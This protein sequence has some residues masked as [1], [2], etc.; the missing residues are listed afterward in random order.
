MKKV[1]SV[2]IATLMLISAFA[3]AETA[4]PETRVTTIVLEGME[5][6]ITET[7]YTNEAGYSIWYQADL[8]QL[9]VNEDQAHLFAIDSTV[10]GEEPGLTTSSAY[11]LIVPVEI[12]YEDTDA[13]LVEAT[14]GFDPSAAVISKATSE[15]LE[16]GVEIKS[17]TVTEDTTFYGFYIVTNG[18]KVLCISTICPIEAVE[19]WGARFDHMVMGIEF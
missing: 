15:T 18:E 13:F 12:A 14:G 19:G 8:F 7:L 1:I 2:I 9:N 6:E 4:E 17:L 11:M 16:N 5:E 3:F 10:E